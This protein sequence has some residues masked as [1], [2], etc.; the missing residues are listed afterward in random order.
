MRSRVGTV[1]HG[2]VGEFVLTEIASTQ[3]VDRI[4]DDI[5]R[6]IVSESHL[7]LG[8]G[9]PFGVEVPLARH[10]VIASVG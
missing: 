5:E 7:V 4:S 10:L 9:S 2:S 3:P 8:F 6:Q 1:R